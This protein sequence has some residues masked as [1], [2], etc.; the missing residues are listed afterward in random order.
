MGAF[1]LKTLQC[2]NVSQLAKDQC[3][4]PTW[5]SSHLHSLMCAPHN[6]WFM[7]QL[8]IRMFSQCPDCCLWSFTSNKAK[9]AEW[10]AN[11][12]LFF[13][14]HPPH[15]PCLLWMKTDATLL[16]SWSICLSLAVNHRHKCLI[17]TGKRFSSHLFTSISSFVYF[18]AL[19]IVR[20]SWLVYTYC[21]TVFNK[22]LMWLSNMLT[23][24]PYWAKVCRF[25]NMSES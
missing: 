1:H 5:F 25:V 17:C 2:V 23:I 20:T 13:K 4:S 10:F 19:H 22:A 15:W 3:Y 7:T 9:R 8:I 21:I 16:Y 11:S 18:V 24:T 14:H 12:L 6:L